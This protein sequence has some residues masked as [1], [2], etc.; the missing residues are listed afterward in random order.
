MKRLLTAAVGIP[1]LLAVIKIGPAWLWFVVVAL[2]AALATREAC[3]LLRRPGRR[4]LT[5]L[6]MTASVLLASPLLLARTLAVEPERGAGAGAA[7]LFG[8]PLMLALVA[9]VLASALT[10]DSM[11]EMVDT[12]M[13]TLFPVMF[14]GLPSGFLTGLRV[15]AEDE[16]GRD[17]VILLLVVVWVGD[18]AAYYGGSLLGRHPLSPRIS[19]RKTVEGAVAGLAGGVGA[20]I[21]A[22]YWWF[23]ALPLPHAIAIGLVLGAVGIGGDLAE[24]ILKR[25]A[26]SKDS[27]SMLPGHG[28]MLDRIDSLLFAGPALYYYYLIVL[29]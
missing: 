15:A 18:T 21:L 13:T 20:A 3:A 12:A 4:P 26:G 28:G 11:E 23:R 5:A 10:R 27:S 1:V 17:L 2:C 25:A 19:P 6:A 24:S 16:T 7:I 22:H 29:R 9:T 14:V 8:L